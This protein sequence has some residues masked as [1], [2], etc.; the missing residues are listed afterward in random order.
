MDSNSTTYTTSSG[1]WRR[2]GVIE[3]VSRLDTFIASFPLDFVAKGGD[4][5]WGYV[6]F[7]VTLLLEVEP[8]HQGKI[9]DQAGHP[10]DLDL[11]PH[12]GTYR[13]IENGILIRCS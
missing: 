6:T 12:A 13:Y 4:N 2:G 11:P 8:L 7:A 10:M 9:V 3:I 5:T 1:V